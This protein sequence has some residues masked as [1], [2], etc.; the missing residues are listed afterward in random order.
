MNLV[1]DGLSDDSLKEEN[2]NRMLDGLQSAYCQNE[3]KAKVGLASYDMSVAVVW[4]SDYAL[5]YT[6]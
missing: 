5:F 3:E 6:N 1:S 2:S 4:A